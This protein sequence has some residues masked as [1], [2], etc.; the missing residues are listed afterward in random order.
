MKYQ[1]G[2]LKKLTLNTYVQMSE[3]QTLPPQ[4]DENTEQKVMP[5]RAI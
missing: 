2:L 1:T 3:L 5:K 4:I